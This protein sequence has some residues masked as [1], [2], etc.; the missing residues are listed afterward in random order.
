MKANK[1]WNFHYKASIL[2]IELVDINNNGELEIIAFTKTGML[3][4]ISLEGKLL[5][6]EVISKN[7]P[8]W[9][10]RI[11]DIDNDGKNEIIL[12]GIDGILRIF[13]CTFAYN[14]EPLWNHKFNSSISGILIEDINNDNVNELIVFSLDKT[15]R[16]LNPSDG[17]LIWAQIFEDGIGDAIVFK[18]NKINT[19]KEVLACGNDGTIRCYD[20]NNGNLLWFKKYSEKLRVITYMNKIKEQL[21]LSGGDDKKL[22]ILNKLTQNEI[23]TLQFNNYVWK[24]I[25]YPF[26]ALNNVLVSSYSFAFFNESTPIQ[27]IDFNSKLICLNEF[28]D[29]QWELNGYNIEYLKITKIDNTLL[30]IVGTTK[31]ELM[32]IE[33]QTGNV[34]FYRNFNSCINMAQLC[35]EKHLLFSCHDDGTII[36]HKFQKM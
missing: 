27:N 20:G 8:L 10:M 24:C 15:L 26:P 19:N 21:V 9:H 34:K 12:G 6:Q 7:S 33:E 23:K 1:L 36:A 22:H 25:T 30:I 35:V 31:G 28:F 14:V 16:V 18:N 4:F 32:I 2:G 3:L 13:K 17:K 11:Y 29:T 5:H